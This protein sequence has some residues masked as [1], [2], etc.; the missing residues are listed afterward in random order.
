MKAKPL[1]TLAATIGGVLKMPIPNTMPTMRATPSS[2]VRLARGEARSGACIE[3]LA[4]M[5]R[6][7]KAAIEDAAFP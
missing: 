5:V 3:D 2:T 4:R 1:S 7:G 6:C